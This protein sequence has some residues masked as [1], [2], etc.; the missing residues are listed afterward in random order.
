MRD[1]KEGRKK[2]ARLNK[3]QGKATQ[4]TQDMYILYTVYLLTNVHY[5][6]QFWF[7]GQPVIEQ[8][9]LSTGQN[10]WTPLCSV[11]NILYIIS[12]M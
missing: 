8:S 9:Q 10:H 6:V 11:D 1:E 12:N 7:V 3:Q 4:H 5:V 2:Q